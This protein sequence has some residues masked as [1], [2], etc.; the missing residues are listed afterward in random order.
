MQPKRYQLQ[1]AEEVK[2]WLKNLPPGGTVTIEIRGVNQDADR[3]VLPEI[4][5]QEPA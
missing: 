5:S 1:V 4:K 3:R 2:G